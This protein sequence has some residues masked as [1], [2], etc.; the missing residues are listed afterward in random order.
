MKSVEEYRF[1]EPA[2]LGTTRLRSPIERQAAGLLAELAQFV[3]A[4]PLQLY[5]AVPT[6]F[7]QSSVGKH[8]RHG[9]DHFDLLRAGIES[10]L[11]D[12]DQ[13]QRDETT[14][15]QPEVAISRVREIATWLERSELPLRHELQVRALADSSE[16]KQSIAYLRSSVERELHFVTSHLI[17]HMGIIRILVELGGMKVPD[18]FGKAVSTVAH[19]KK[20]SVG[21]SI[22]R[23]QK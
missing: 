3:E 4:L 6:T 7:S 20:S 12:Y 1:A 15:F 9:L 5:Q 21:A 16:S 17:H 19:E 2:T 23:K 22:A 8:I 10:G 18:P 11:I 13:R 14:E